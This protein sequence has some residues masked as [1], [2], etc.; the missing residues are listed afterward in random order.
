[1]ALSFHSFITHQYL[2]HERNLGVVEEGGGGRGRGS[3]EGGRG[4]RA[5]PYCRP[6][7][8]F[9][10]DCVGLIGF[11][12]PLDSFRDPGSAGTIPRRGL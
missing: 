1:M 4:R 8:V 3:G 6:L 9:V 5:P 2:F 11:S 10:W 12:P 7:I